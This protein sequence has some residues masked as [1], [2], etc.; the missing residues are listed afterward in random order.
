M[1]VA[2]L[3]GRGLIL[4]TDYPVVL[5]LFYLVKAGPPR[6]ALELGRG[7]VGREIAH[8]AVE[9]APPFGVVLDSVRETA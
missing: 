1:L 5:L 9:R 8:G 2:R 7:R 3:Q 6:A 4:R